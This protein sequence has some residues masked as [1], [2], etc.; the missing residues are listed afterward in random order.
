M[1]WCK[2][3]HG[4]SKTAMVFL[5]LNALFL[6]SVTISANEITSSNSDS[7]KII[8][9]IEN[10]EVAESFSTDDFDVNSGYL[11][12][13][14]SSTKDS[15]VWR[16]NLEHLRELENEY[17]GCYLDLLT[18]NLNLTIPF[19]STKQFYEN[20]ENVFTSDYDQY[21]LEISFLN[22]SE[23]INSEVI[24]AFEKSFPKSSLTGAIYEINFRIV[25]KNENQ[26]SV[27][28]NEFKDYFIFSI[29][30]PE[31]SNAVLLY[32]NGLFSFTPAMFLNEEALVSITRGGIF[33][34]ANNNI[35]FQDVPAHSWYRDIIQAAANICV[36]RGINESNFRPDEYITRGEFAVMISD[37]LQL[38]RTDYSLMYK[39]VSRDSWYF[40]GI[41]KAKTALILEPFTETDFE[42]D[43]YL[44]REEMACILASALRFRN[45]AVTLQYIDLV[46]VFQDHASINK[47]Y[48]DNIELVYRTNIMHGM[49]NRVFNPKG[50]ST[51]AQAAVAQYK[52]LQALQ[53]I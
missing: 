43:K 25:D 45:A 34:T 53:L 5:S 22:E 7:Y 33:L 48:M 31:N 14:S 44:T 12:I 23:T 10:G 3:R 6:S 46:S 16:I 50:Y 28:L 42:P 39:D 2:L 8:E 38:N 47:L 35:I 9:L 17:A 49:G 36:I 15:F 51:R 18:P 37:A 27:D 19:N 32:E 11:T 41:A 21:W 13:K 29:P 20:N 52:L 30:C 40:N 1:Y 4:F 26:L 24:T